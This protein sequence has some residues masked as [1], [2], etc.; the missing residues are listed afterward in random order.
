MPKTVQ[1][2][3]TCLLDTLYPETCEAVVRVLER[4]GVEVNLPGGQARCG[5]LAHQTAG[6]ETSALTE[7]I[8]R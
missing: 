4:A 5:Q 1:L 2:F 8:V 6:D 3:I 7:E